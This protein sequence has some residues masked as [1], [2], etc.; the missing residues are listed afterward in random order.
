MHIVL[1]DGVCNLCNGVVRFLIERDRRSRF[2]FGMLQ[3]DAAQVLL[4]GSEL[5][6]EDLTTAVYLRRGRI[7]TRSTAALYILKDLGGLWALCFAFI[8]VPPFIRDAVYHWVSRNRY[9][10]FGRRESCMLP[11]PELRARFIDM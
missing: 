4:R 3:G 5:H 11:T 9:Q 2:L 8:V 10:W 7:L 1:F 6:P